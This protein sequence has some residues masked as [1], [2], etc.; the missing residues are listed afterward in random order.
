MSGAVTIATFFFLKESN[1][2]ILLQRKTLALRKDHADATLRSSLEKDVPA[3]QLLLISIVRPFKL[4]FR[5]PIV[6]MLSIITG[7]VYGI[8]YLCLTTFGLVFQQQYGFSEG[9]SGLCYLGIGLGSFIGLIFIGRYSDRIVTKLANS[10]D[11][12]LRKPEYRLPLVL[13]LQWAVPTGLII[14]GWSADKH[15]HWIVPIIGS[16]VFSFGTFTI[17]IQ[18]STYLIDAFTLYS[19]SALAA[20]TILRSLLGALLPLC[21]PVRF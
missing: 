3:R 5:S 17:F 15:V 21:G 9:S 1:P 19:A 11:S 14:Y 18:F 7:F 10:S 4:L 2:I 20:T 6:A 13:Y 16:M 12:N 8:L